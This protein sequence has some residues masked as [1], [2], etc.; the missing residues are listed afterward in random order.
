MCLVGHTRTYFVHC[1]VVLIDAHLGG[2]AALGVTY[3]AAGIAF[4]TGHPAVG[5]GILAAPDAAI[6]AAG[7]A[8]A[9][10][11]TPASSSQVMMKTGWAS[12]SASG[13]NVGF[14]GM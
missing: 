5:A 10:G 9:G 13:W 6:Y 12:R 11:F 14:L 3:A 7:Y 1:E 8:L 4:G 2:L